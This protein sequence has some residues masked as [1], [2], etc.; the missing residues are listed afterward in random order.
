M[1]YVRTL[2]TGPTGDVWIAG[3]TQWSQEG[4]PW[5]RH[6]HDEECLVIDGAITFTDLVDGTVVAH[7]GTSGTYF[8]RPA[9][10][11]HAGPGSGCEETSLS[12]HRAVGTLRTE[13]I[14][15]GGAVT[16]T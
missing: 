3:A 4:E 2:G 10:M 12:F 9:G 8:Y 11:I 14:D 5:H 1:R 13:W 7:R 6:P 16:T 15:A